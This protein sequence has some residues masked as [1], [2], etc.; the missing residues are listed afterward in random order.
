MNKNKLHQQRQ[1]SKQNEHKKN[2]HKQQ[3]AALNLCSLLSRNWSNQ[4]SL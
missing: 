2:E 4:V 1:T 3:P